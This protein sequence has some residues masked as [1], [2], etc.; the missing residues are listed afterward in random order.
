MKL[1]WFIDQVDYSIRFEGVI[2]QND[3][4]KL[5]LN[6]LEL[7]MLKECNESKRAS[8]FLLAAEMLFRREEEINNENRLPEIYDEYGA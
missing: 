2:A 3:L 5:N 6:E 8:D 1:T 4:I 7:E